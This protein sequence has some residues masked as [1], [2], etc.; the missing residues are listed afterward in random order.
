MATANYSGLSGQAYWAERAMEV[1]DNI[2][3]DVKKTDKLLADQY[4]TA[5]DEIQASLSLFYTK[6]AEEN[7]VSYTEAMKQM[8]AYDISNYG[9]RMNQLKQRALATNNPFVIAEME[10]L[11]QVGKVARFQ[12]LMA[13]IDAQLVLLGYEQQISMEE[14]LTGVYESAY[15]QTAFT[16]QKATGVGVALAAINPSYVQEALTFPWSGD[17]FSERIWSN[18][19]K[20]VNEMRQ[21]I[22]QGMIQGHSVQKM[23][24]ELSGKMDSSYKNS[25]RL[26]RTETAYV[27]TEATAKN[28]QSVGLAQY[29]FIGTLDS[30][31]SKLCQDL[32]GKVFN[33]EDKQ[34][35]KNCVPM[36][37]NCR[38]AIAPYFSPED[39]GE[40]RARDID[41]NNFIVPNM[42]YH[43]WA[44]IYLKK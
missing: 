41:G 23:S 2:Y 3:K 32:D 28:Y 21:T 14:A 16:I 24:R 34:V 17:Q 6:Y 40:R 13:Q 26:I 25:L 20:L 5:L 43:E 44:A 35:G 7:K 11:F 27:A 15:Y 4:K 18:R 33:L 38:S 19:T 29:I 9:N 10:K 37:P 31:T 22:T 12:A 42:T 36:H 39:L 30:K 8:D 1:Q